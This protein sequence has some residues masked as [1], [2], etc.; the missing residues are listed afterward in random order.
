VLRTLLRWCYN[1]STADQ[2]CFSRFLR[3]VLL[4]IPI[5]RNITFHRLIAKVVAFSAIGHTLMHFLN[6]AN[7]PSQTLY[8]FG[9]WPW[10]SGGLIVLS[11]LFIYS[12][13][14]ENT[15]MGQFE[16]FWYN[17]HFFITFFG[18]LLSHGHYGYQSNFWRWFLLPGALYLLERILRLYRAYQPVALLSV[19]VMKP[20]VFSLEFAKEGVFKT[21]YKEGQYLFLQCPPVSQIQWHPFTISSAPEEKGVTVHIRHYGDQSWTGQVLNYVS[22]LA[23]TLGQT[24]YTLPGQAGHLGQTH[25]ADGRRMFCLDGPHSAPTQHVGEYSTVM[26][27]GA[28][29]G[30]TPVASTLKSVVFHRW[31]YSLG[32]TFPESAYFLWV[33]SHGEIDSF[34]FFVRWMKDA[35]DEVAHMRAGDAEGMRNK[36]FA[37]HCY[38]T[39]APKDAKQ[40]D[41]SGDDNDIGFWGMPRE[42]RKVLKTQSSFMER[43]LYLAMK[44]PK[45]GST[46][47]FGDIYIH[48]GRPKW[49]QRFDEVRKAHPTGEVGVTFCGNP[50]I[51]DD[52]AKQCHVASRGRKDGIFK[53][54]KENF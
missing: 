43:D 50:L 53:F 6:Y 18:F 33:C 28:G 36:G 11:M 10:V 30:V 45:T 8:I 46:Q 52:L 25:G 13:A 48:E 15:K 38:I 27:I 22:K 21:P 49:K 44:C 24:Y 17:H 37:I 19:T 3:F 20:N 54:H 1:R 5:D 51:A 41:L 12:A 23:P 35:Q 47:Q 42:E 16:I 26:V 40:P 29:I 34:R 4:F 7:A 2:G 14:F 32:K 9:V 31:K 39:S